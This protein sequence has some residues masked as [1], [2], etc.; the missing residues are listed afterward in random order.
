MQTPKTLDEAI[1]NA[2][3]VGPLSELRERL[4]NHVKD[5]MAQRFGVA[6]LGARDAEELKLLESLFEG[7]TKRSEK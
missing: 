1:T 3:C 6:Y 5:F 4:Y 2:L 7:L